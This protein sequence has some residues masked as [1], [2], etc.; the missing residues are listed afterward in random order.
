MKKLLMIC[1]VCAALVCAFALSSVTA[2][3]APADGLVMDYFDGG[4]SNLQVTFNHSTHTSA[5]C[6]ECHHV[7]GADQYKSCA[8]AGCHD[9]MDQKDKTPASYYKITHKKA[10]LSTCITCHK[11]V[12]PDKETKKLLTGCKN[13]AC[14]P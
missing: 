4:D 13:S 8:A 14:H 10:A 2:Q 3:D 11:E 12:A 7:E 5:A 6:E 1:M 9:V